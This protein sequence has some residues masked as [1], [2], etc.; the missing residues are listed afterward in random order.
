V[1]DA[2]IYE[3]HANMTSNENVNGNDENVN[4]NENGE[5]SVNVRNESVNGVNEARSKEQQ[6][7]TA[8]AAFAIIV[9]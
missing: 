4:G 3:L 6:T 2:G 9:L 1:R 7:T 5:N 8:I